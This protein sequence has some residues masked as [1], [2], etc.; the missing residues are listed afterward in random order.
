LF[1]VAHV[2]GCDRDRNVDRDVDS[3]CRLGRFELSRPLRNVDDDDNEESSSFKHTGPDDVSM[4]SSLSSHTRLPAAANPLQVDVPTLDLGGVAVFAGRCAAVLGIRRG[5][6]V[7]M[8]STTVSIDAD[9]VVCGA[10]RVVGFS[11]VRNLCSVARGVTRSIGGVV[12]AA[13]TAAVVSG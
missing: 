5:E 12:V 13:A 10:V 8:A 1:N 9:V 11:I 6:R 2:V 7:M 4:H 3:V